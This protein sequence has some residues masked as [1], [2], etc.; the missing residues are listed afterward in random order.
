MLD[1]YKW[2]VIW[3]H[4][5]S[6]RDGKRGNLRQSTPKIGHT[7]GVSQGMKSF[8]HKRFYCV[9]TVK[10]RGIGIAPDPEG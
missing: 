10:S 8:L 1:S 4:L 9:F 6:Q 7:A 3:P 2:S 5:S